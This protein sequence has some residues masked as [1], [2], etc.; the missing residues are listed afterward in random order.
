MISTLP[1]KSLESLRHFLVFEGKPHFF[2]MKLI[3]IDQKYG[4]DVVNVVNYY[5]SSMGYL[6]IAQKVRKF[7]FGRLCCNNASRQ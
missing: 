3:E 1:F 6:N 7:V 2:L 4:V 5:Y